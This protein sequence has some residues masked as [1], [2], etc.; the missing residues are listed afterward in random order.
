MG[1][2]EGFENFC[3][4][5]N[6]EIY[7]FICGWKGNIFILSLEGF[8]SSMFFFLFWGKNNLCWFWGSMFKFC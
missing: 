7:N 6:M 3:L 8:F 4:N 5:W 2:G 1:E